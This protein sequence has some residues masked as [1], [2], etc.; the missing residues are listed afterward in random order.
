MPRCTMAARVACDLVACSC[1]LLTLAPDT[2][3]S[4]PQPPASEEK[5]RAAVKLRRL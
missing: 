1:A 4:G 2:C 3:A 5:H